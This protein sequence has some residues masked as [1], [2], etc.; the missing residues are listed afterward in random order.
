MN[1]MPLRRPLQKYASFAAF[2][3]SRRSDCAGIRT[4]SEMLDFFF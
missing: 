4:I 3:A 1:E 2:F